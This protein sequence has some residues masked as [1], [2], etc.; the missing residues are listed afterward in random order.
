M[1]RIDSVTKYI[2]GTLRLSKTVKLVNDDFNGYTNFV[3][4]PNGLMVT[5][6]F[7]WRPIEF[8]QFELQT[9]S[10]QSLKFKVLV[11]TVEVQIHNYLFILALKINRKMK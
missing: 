4:A 2:E 9:D 6:K 7:L 10:F 3:N 5:G 8:K 11:P 1:L